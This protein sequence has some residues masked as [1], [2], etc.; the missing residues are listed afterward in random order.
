MG[1]NTHAVGN[2]LISLQ[3]ALHIHGSA[4]TDSA[5]KD[6]VALW[7][8]FTEKKHLPISRPV[9]FK[10]KGQL[11]CESFCQSH[12]EIFLLFSSWEPHRALK[13]KTT[14]CGRVPQSV[15]I[16]NFSLSSS[17]TVSNYSPKCLFMCS[18]R[19]MAPAAAGA[20]A[21]SKQDCCSRFQGGDLPCK[22]HYL[23]I[24]RKGFDF[25]FV[26]VYFDVKMSVGFQVLYILELKS[27]FLSLWF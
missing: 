26:K 21:P 20:A 13:V 5:T 9:L 19:C 11:Q 16:R 23:L 8:V 18:Y 2:P 12:E 24:P 14:M 25:Q 4:F 27:S 10:P 17:S 15:V 6:Y 7:Y 22:S 1:T 3:Y